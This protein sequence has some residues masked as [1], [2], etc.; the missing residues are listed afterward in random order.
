[1]CSS[2]LWRLAISVDVNHSPNWLL[3]LLL[4]TCRGHN[5]RPP[6]VDKA[7]GTLRAAAVVIQERVYEGLNPN[8]NPGHPQ[9]LPGKPEASKDSNDDL[10]VSDE[11]LYQGIHPHCLATCLTTVVL[12]ALQMSYEL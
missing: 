11:E 10:M 6:W 1:M 3:Y 4:Q 5:G 8:C 12:V 9:V 7:Q 2:L